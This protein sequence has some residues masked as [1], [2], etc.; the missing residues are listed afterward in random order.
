MKCQLVYLLNLSES[1]SLIFTGKDVGGAAL[2][3]KLTL[4]F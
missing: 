4:H 1:M 3:G 2:T